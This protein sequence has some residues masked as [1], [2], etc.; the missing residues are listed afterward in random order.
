[1]TQEQLRRNQSSPWPRLALAVALLFLLEELAR[2]AIW[3]E[4]WRSFPS[5]FAEPS[6]WY[7][8]GE[9]LII[10]PVLVLLTFAGQWDRNRS[11]G[12]IS[13]A[14][15]LMWLGAGLNLLTLIFLSER[16]WW[17]AW[18][19]ILVII[20]IFAPVILRELAR[21]RQVRK[22]RLLGAAVVLLL[23]INYAVS[24]PDTGGMVVRL[25]APQPTETS[26]VTERWRQD[27]DFLVSELTR[28]HDDPFTKIS[29]D[30]F[31]GE[32]DKLR[33]AI[34]SLEEHVIF[35]RMMRLVAKI[36][37]Q[38][39]CMAPWTN[40]NLREYPVRFYWLSDGFF[41]A[42]S[43]EASRY[44]LG[45]RVKRIGKMDIDR[46][47]ELV[48]ELIPHDNQAQLLTRSHAYLQVPEILHA[49]GVLDDMENAPFVLEDS[50]LNEYTVH[51]K[52]EQV[53][54]ENWILWPKRK[55]LW[56][57]HPGD[58]YWYEI[59]PD[60]SLLYFRYRRSRE[61]APNDFSDFC[62][63][64][65]LMVDEHKLQRIVVDFRGNNGGSSV[66]FADFM[67]Q[68]N[69]RPWLKEEG[70]LFIIVNRFTLG[71][72]LHSAMWL[73]SDFGA[74]TFG[75]KPGPIP[76]ICQ[77]GKLQLPNCGVTVAYTA[78]KNCEGKPGGDEI[79]PFIHVAVAP[80]SRHFWDGTD[81]VM[82]SL[83]AYIDRLEQEESK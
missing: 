36:G 26:S 51:L 46:V 4:G 67:N 17:S 22:V 70:R 76:S 63:R 54:E 27:L 33:R 72:A 73:Q 9:L 62:S 41:V 23:V 56:V 61:T 59:F 1:M 12:F 57:Q 10:A 24:W 5:T 21:G 43:S 29:Q 75:E 40:P 25:P 66:P 50:S 19:P 37:D 52:P 16:L 47:H 13:K 49:L 14:R 79:S 77:V 71:G 44:L 65:F 74:V 18:L 34:P 53:G 69:E 15:W 81:P 39:T 83:I 3:V 2:F 32:V 28:L 78:V 68:V 11:A 82:D 7:K 48:A 58:N 60:T 38:Y 6:I 64:M 31:Y 80:S 35:T 8:I 30:E 45:S 20:G 55:A 42:R